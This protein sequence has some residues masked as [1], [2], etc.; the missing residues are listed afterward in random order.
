MEGGITHR[1]SLCG[2]PD[3]AGLAGAGRVQ[4]GPITRR[5]TDEADGHRS[6]VSQAQHLETRTGPQDLPLSAAKAAYHPAQSGLGDGHYLH[7]DGARFHLSGR[8]AGLVHAARPGMARVDH[9]GGGFL[10][11]SCGRGAG[12]ARH[13]RNIQYGSGQSVHLHQLHQGAGGAGDQDQHGRK[14]RLAGQCLG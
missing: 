9:A 7:S 10:H 12:E 13:A 2:Q 1:V 11:R 5:H 8:R 3:V 14:G 6:L 4:G